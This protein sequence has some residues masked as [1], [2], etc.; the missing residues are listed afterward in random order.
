MSSQ[1]PQAPTVFVVGGTGAQGIPV[2]RGLVKDGA[3]RVRFLTRDANSARAKHLISLGDVE[4]IEGTFASEEDLRKGFR[5][6]QYAFVNIDGFNSG[7]K[8]EIFWAIRSYELAL[9]EGIQFFVYGNLD[10]AYKKS[11]YKPQFRTGHYDGKGRIGEWV[12]Q[13][14]KNP[15][16]AA[17]MGVAVFTTGPYFDMIVG[18]GTPMSPRVEDGVVTWR[19]PLGDG[20]VCHVDLDDCE[21]YVRWLFDHQKRANGM[22][23]EVGTELVAY[24]DLASA[25]EKVTGHPARYIDTDLDTYWTSGPFGEGTA[26][27]GYNS[28]PKDP[29]AMTI[30]QNFTGFWNTWKASGGNNGLIQRDFKLLDEIHPK[31]IKS[32]EDWFR[33]EEKRGIEN[34]LGSL[35]DRVNNL[36]PVLKIAE[37]GR[38]GRL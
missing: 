30:R 35:W 7:E 2:I 28:D 11:G 22:D 5:G 29:A 13:Q 3:Y 6:A 24:K 14:N 17:R 21:H 9:E 27:S 10:Y 36:K 20:A 32:V 34:G 12:L 18:R 8:T 16:N 37:D 4:P 26:S 15:H 38:K 25:F 33:R 1:T 19:V 31:R 23:L